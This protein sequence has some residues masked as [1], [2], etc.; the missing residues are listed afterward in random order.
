LLLY[1][2]ISWLAPLAARPVARGLGKA[3]WMV[4]GVS[5][6]LARENTLRN[7]RRTATT[8]ATLMVGVSLMALTAIVASSARASIGGAI[9]SGLDAQLVLTG[10]ELF[11][12]SPGARDAVANDPTVADA[13]AVRLGNARVNGTSTRI[14][15]VEPSSF[16]RLADLGIQ[17]GSLSALGPDDVLVHEGVAHDHHWHV[18]D[19]VVMQFARTGALPARIAGIY[20]RNQIVFASYVIPL[21]TYEAGF[22][23]QQDSFVYVKLRR[24]VTEAEG[25][26]SVQRSVRAFPTVQVHN[27]D[28]F[29]STLDDQV[30]MALGVIWALL[31][32]AVLTGVLGIVNTLALSVFERT[33]EIGLL[34]TVGMARRQVWAMIGGEAVLIALVG[35]LLGIALGWVLAWVL[36]RIL[37]DDGVDVFAVPYLQLAGFFVLAGIAGMAASIVPAWR[38]SR[39]DILDAIAHE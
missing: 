24:T 26:A 19:R 32:L 16:A 29:S 14:A 15:A 21:S 11:P 35:A 20:T 6:V 12:F 34:R 31:A 23:T 22:G 37:A 25:R 8:A 18:G 5:G 10:P 38:G 17:Q 4:A 13:T 36:E 1:V 28:E 30:Q 39:L 2:G 9:D 27:H 7:A 33:R 3:L